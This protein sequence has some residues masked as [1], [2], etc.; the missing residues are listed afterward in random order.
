[1]AEV[2]VIRGIFV[3]CRKWD[4]CYDKAHGIVR[5]EFCVLQFQDIVIIGN[6]VAVADNFHSVN[7]HFPGKVR[8]HLFVGQPIFLYNFSHVVNKFIVVLP[9]GFKGFAYTSLGLCIDE[10]NSY[11]IRLK[12]SL[13]AVY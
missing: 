9:L 6:T 2:S 7:A 8:R 12:E 13:Q 5:I 4:R 1:M 10:V 3:L 11:Y